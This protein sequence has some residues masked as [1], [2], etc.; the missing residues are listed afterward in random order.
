MDARPRDWFDPLEGLTGLRAPLDY[1]IL[2]V[3]G[4]GNFVL[5]FV[6]Y[7]WPPERYFDE[8][9]FARAGAEYLQNLPLNENTHPPLSK[10][11]IA[12][13]MM[14]FG[15]MPAG[16]GLGG[17]TALNAVIGH[18]NDGD[19][20]Y[21]WRFLDVVF[22]ALSVMLLYALAK[23][24]TGSSAFATVAALLLTF[25]GM[26]F[27][28]SRIATPEG[29]VILFSTL[30]VYAFYRFWISSQVGD[31]AYVA[32]PIW[33]FAAGGIGSLGA[34]FGIA[35]ACRALW[36]LDTA[37]TV[38]ASLYFACGTYLVVRYVIFR[39][40]FGDGRRELSYAEGSYALR[41]AGKVTIYTADG[42]SIDSRGKLTR[43]AVSQGE[44]GALVYRNGPLAIRYARDGSVTYESPDGR[45]V[46]ARDE[47][48]APGGEILEKGRSSRLWLLVFAVAFG[49][50]VSTKWYGV[51]GFGVGFVLLIAIAL[52]R[53]IL[54]RR[55]ALW[56]NPRG[57]RLDGA[58]AT[59]LFVSATVY[60]LVWVPDLARQAP[61]SIV[62]NVNDV[63]YLQYRMF[64]YHETL[65][66]KHQYASK[67]WEWPLDYVPIVYFGVYAPDRSRQVAAGDRC[68][69][70]IINALPNPVILWFGLFCVPFVAVLAWRE[71]RKG[72][73]L[74]V[75]A[76]LLQWLPW[77][78]SPRIA[79][80]YHF[81]VDIPLICLCNAIFLQ[82][83]WQWC[84]QRVNLR[85]VGYAA[86]G[87]YTAAT[88]AFFV[89][90]YPLLT[91]HP[92]TW[93]AWQQRMW[94]HTWVIGPG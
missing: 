61:D 4:L 19:N 25:D 81:L 47:I 79:F 67:W 32:V 71:R 42:G 91:F 68:C 13:S 22:G 94:L 78:A 27:V 16:H 84:R 11:L 93:N 89:Y 49:L 24:V 23:R 1:A 73:A 63:V 57:Y 86:V 74:V 53:Y 60:A 26:H 46:Y 5:S 66:A 28:Q 90:F 48:H 39:W 20:A 76:Y 92:V 15:G 88:F 44:K 40:W 38:T 72:Y 64:E 43:G 29:F 69:V 45:A 80:E 65:K 83:V 41:D 82:R 37:A 50:L 59:V 75:L 7:W 6:G 21:G 56:G 35:S 12:F 36:N 51:M 2:A 30:T 17:W 58:L 9:Y 62:Q 85:W 54:A 18:L 31:R 33:A 34:G 52:Q 3:L 77:A 87:S 10:L 8:N 70:Y 55:P 14:L